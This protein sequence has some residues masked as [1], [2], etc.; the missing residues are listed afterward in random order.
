MNKLFIVIKNELTRYF[1]SPLAYVYLLTFLLLNGSFAIYFGDFFNRGQAD[2]LSMFSFQ[3]WLYLLFIPGISMRLWSEEF[4]TKTIVQIVT[5][6][7]SIKSLV[8]GKFF[9]SWIFCGLALILT[10]PFWITINVLG[11]PDNLV[12]LFGYLAS[13]II[14]GC[15]LAISQTMSALTKNQVIALVLAVI[16]N[17]VFFWSGIEYILSFFRLFLPN[18][19]IDVIASFSFITH[20]DTLTMGLIELRDIIFFLSIIIFFNFTTILIINFKTAGTSGWLKSTNKAYYIFAW[21]FLLL[22]FLG[23]NIIA[24]NQTRNIYFDATS[25][26][27]FT[28]SNNTKYILK[29]LKEPVLGKLYFSNIL[30]QRNPD[31]R[32]M[33]DNVRILLQKYRDISEG[34]FD[35]KVYNPKFLSKEEDIAIADGIQPVPLID[36]NQNALFGLSLEDEINNKNVIPFFATTNSGELEQIITSKIYQLHHKKKSIGVVSGLPLFGSIEGDGSVLG[37]HW[38]II[39]VW[40]ETYNVYNIV[41]DEDFNH[42]FDALVLFYPQNLSEVFIDKIKEYSKNSGKILLILDPANEASRLYSYQNKK[43]QASSVDELTDFWKIKFYKDYVVA[44]LKNSLTVDTTEDYKENPTFSQDVIQ[45]RT[46]KN[47]M[48]PYHAIT[49]NLQSIMFASASIISPNSSAIDEG[50]IEFTPLIRASDVS[51]VMTS[52]VVLDGL[53]PQE[54][55][56]YFVPD[57]NQ[58]IIAA[59]VRGLEADNQ[60][61]LVVV[62]DSDFLYEKFWAKNINLLENTY[63]HS[64]YDNAN[65]TI[66]ALDFLIGNDDLIGLRGKTTTSKKFENIEKIRRENSFIYKKKENELLKKINEVQQGLQEIW[67]KKDFEE[68]ENFTPDELSIIAN[69]R[70]NLNSLKEELSILRMSAFENIKVIERKVIFVN[71]WLIPSIITGLIMFTFLIKNRKK[72]KGFNFKPDIPFTRLA[73]SCTLLLLLGVISISLSNKSSVDEFEGKLAFPDIAKNINNIEKIS[74]QSNKSSLTFIKKDGL[75]ILEENQLLPVYQERIRK[76]LTTL[77]DASFYEKKSNKAENLH[78]FDLAPIENKSSNVLQIEIF[79]PN[80][81]IQK[82]ELGKINLDLGRGSKAAFVK[83]ENQFQVWKIIADFVDM[84]L[85]YKNWTYKHLWDLRFGRFY[86]KQNNEKEEDRLLYLMKTLLNVEYSDID[87]FK[88]YSDLKPEN[89]I[90]LNVEDNNYVT[91]YFYKTDDK[92]FVRYDFAEENQNHH[93]KLFEMYIKDKVVFIDTNI[94]EIILEQLRK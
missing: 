52:K 65:F 59:E 14:A 66:N 47:D 57:D 16:A 88:N 86:S 90:K 84:N 25:E 22:A 7:I 72:L 77:A 9:A 48:N 83:F 26:K 2:L 34:K 31:L 24:N 19:I 89:H 56:N 50:K 68:R 20:F 93:L 80:N 45:F 6:P 23:T 94:M 30:G 69:V 21:F 4:R 63:T 87:D 54:I 37:Q 51:S 46:L 74:I 55:L 32:T 82:F 36:L 78:L 13:F 12:I 33:F 10:F 5:M 53:N 43:L 76:L 61:N 81:L 17:L 70:N 41:K 71:I 15:M 29:H 8:L 1:I 40:Q 75:W 35:Y 18:S 73:L 58:K 64:E 39:D 44:D 79:S 11:N 38:K 67:N 92:N 49:K 85:D 42:N 62:A 91:M 60:F 27:I 28:L 3:P